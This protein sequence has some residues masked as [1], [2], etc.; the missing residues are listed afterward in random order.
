MVQI[1]V[2][3]RYLSP[4]QDPKPT[5]TA[6]LQ[7]EKIKKMLSQADAACLAHKVRNSLTHLLVTAIWLHFK[8][9]FMKSGMAK[10]AC[11]LFN[12]SAKHLIKILLGKKYAG[13]ADKKRKT[14]T[15]TPGP[16]EHKKKW[17]SLKSHTAHKDP[18]KSSS[19][20]DDD[21]RGGTQ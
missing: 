18:D 8:W 21:G 16:K 14:E 19:S 5:T 20:S 4:V 10:E 17:K 6:E 15:K 3:E 7:Q 2:P 1:N 11:T 9:K 13:G 12:I